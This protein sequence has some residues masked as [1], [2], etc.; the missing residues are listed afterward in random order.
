MR[1]HVFY[2]KTLC[3]RQKKVET[4]EPMGQ[5]QQDVDEIDDAPEVR[6]DRPTFDD[7]VEPNGTVHL[8]A[9][10]TCSR[11]RGGGGCWKSSFNRAYLY[12]ISNDINVCVYVMRP[13]CE[14]LRVVAWF[15]KRITRE[16]P[17]GARTFAQHLL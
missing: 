13:Y 12:I 14:W 16:A 17:L 9:R 11:N 2:L 3:L 1:A 4:A 8:H 7:V 15:I 5:Y 6:P 10:K